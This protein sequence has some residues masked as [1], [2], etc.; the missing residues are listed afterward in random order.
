MQMFD[1]IMAGY[2]RLRQKA[3]WLALWFVL[4]HWL[5]TNYDLPDGVAVLLNVGS[6]VVLWQKL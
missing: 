5:P 3:P 6:L 4:G 2:G 1:T